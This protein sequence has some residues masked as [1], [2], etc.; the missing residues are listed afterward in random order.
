MVTPPR[1]PAAEILLVAVEELGRILSVAS[2]RDQSLTTACA[3]WTVRDVLAH[4]S[5]S[6]L[7]VIEDRTHGFTPDENEI[8][9]QERRPWPFDRVRDE[10]QTTAGPTAAHIEARGGSLDG[11]GI[12]VWVH[13]G[14]IREALGVADAY[15]GPGIDLALGLLEERSRRLELGVAVTVGDTELHLGNGPATVTVVSDP[16]T[17]VRLAAGR[18]PDPSRYTLTG[19]EPADLVLFS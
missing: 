19:A 5:G 10:L 1:R 4:C 9:V 3:P 12:G 16:D 13:A 7:R 14:D 6:M 8:D 15:A 2:A 17:F 18:N 11:L